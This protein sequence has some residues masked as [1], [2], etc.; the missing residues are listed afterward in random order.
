MINIYNIN[1]KQ[2]DGSRSYP[3]YSYL[4]FESFS[5]L[6]HIRAVIGGFHG[7]QDFNLLKD[8]DLICPTYCTKQQN[9][10]KSRYPNKIVE[11]GVGRIISI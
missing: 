11:G 7:F 8:I 4:F 9:E 6:G 3:D 5:H 1:V 2:D 10:I